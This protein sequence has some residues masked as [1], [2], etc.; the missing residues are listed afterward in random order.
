MKTIATI[1]FAT[2]ALTGAAFAAGDMQGMTMATSVCHGG[3][4]MKM[5]LPP[6][7]RFMRVPDRPAHLVEGYGDHTHKITTAN[8]RRSLFST[9]V[10]GCCSFQSCRGD[11]FVPR[12]RRLDPDCAIV[13]VGRGVRAR[14]TSI[15][16]CRATR[17]RPPWAA[18][19]WR[20]RSNQGSPGKV[21]WIEAL[22]LAMHR[23]ACRPP[24]AR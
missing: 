11:P 4:N 9:R 13:L 21:A 10:C 18:L 22:P 15:F 12:R 19:E 14:P 16:R 17:W 8:P 20:A 2:C 6:M 5:T 23:P 1:L 24:S 3:M 7:P